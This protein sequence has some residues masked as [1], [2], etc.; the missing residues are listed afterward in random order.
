MSQKKKLK[1]IA[2]AMQHTTLTSV[3]L[4]DPRGKGFK[5]SGLIVLPEKGEVSVSPGFRRFARVYSR[6]RT[7]A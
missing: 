6:P 7:Y 3:F 2:V 4:R 1:S 5:Y